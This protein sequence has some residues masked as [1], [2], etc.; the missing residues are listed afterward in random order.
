MFLNGVS[1][2]VYI[3]IRNYRK[4]LCIQ[5]LTVNE[6][7]TSLDGLR[8]LIASGDYRSAVDLTRRLLETS[9]S[10][11]QT[12]ADGDLGSVTP[13][14][15]TT[16]QL[17]TTRLTLMFKLH[18][19][20]AVEAELSAFE[21]LDQPDLFFRFYPVGDFPASARGS[22]APF[23]L[24]VLWAEL[25]AHL[26]KPRDTLD[27]L[28]GLLAV[29][30][31]IIENINSGVSAD[32]FCDP[33]S[34]PEATALALATWRRRRSTLLHSIAN[35]FVALKDVDPAIAIW[36]RIAAEEEDKKRKSVIY[37]SVGRVLLQVGDVVRLVGW[38]VALLVGR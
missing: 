16:L 7:P 11:G 14:T 18:L 17:W 23:A 13:V 30:D 32:G 19:Y 26:G 1:T 9:A 37:S 15:P 28:Y 24:R 6:V 12:D 36:E 20:A 4:N 5:S 10:A 27:R 29:V 8:S 35:I 21:D 3:R 2:A 33:P 34:S 22:L 31:A 25:P 38:K